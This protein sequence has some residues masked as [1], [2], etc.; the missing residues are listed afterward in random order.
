MA[1][2]GRVGAKLRVDAIVSD[3]YEVGQQIGKGAFSTVHLVTKK[4]TGEKFAMKVI[5]KEKL[6]IEA[7]SEE[8]LKREVEILKSVRH[9]N[10][11]PLHELFET[12]NRLYLIME[13]VSGGELFQSIVDKQFYSEEDARAVI[14]HIT[15][16][17]EY[18]HERKIAHRDLKRICSLRAR[19]IPSS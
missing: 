14:S 4:D 19:T 12:D 5:N 16:A 18:L 8:R 9:P 10:I 17:V 3:S 15:S 2:R 11:I 7:K 6:G 1:T 13:L